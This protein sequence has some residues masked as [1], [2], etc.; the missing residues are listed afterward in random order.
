MPR[1]HAIK[2]EGGERTHYVKPD[3]LIM[4]KIEIQNYRQWTRN[5]FKQIIFSLRCDVNHSKYVILIIRHRRTQVKSFFLF[6][7]EK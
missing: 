1:D 7:I 5:V 6:A 3:Q 4:E 2:W